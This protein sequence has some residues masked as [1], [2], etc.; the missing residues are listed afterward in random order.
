[1]SVLRGVVLACLGVQQEAPV[2]TEG[3][4]GRSWWAVSAW[5]LEGRGFAL[6]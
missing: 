6:L 5:G 2:K 4:R 3:L 1:M